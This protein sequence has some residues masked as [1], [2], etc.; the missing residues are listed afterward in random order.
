MNAEPFNLGTSIMETFK[1]DRTGGRP[2]YTVAVK[3]DFIASHFLVGGDW[4]SEN[5][6]H[7]HHYVV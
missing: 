2:M 3:R 6:R 4:G 7:A 1:H 5:E